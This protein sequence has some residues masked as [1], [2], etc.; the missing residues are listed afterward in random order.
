MT[1]LSDLLLWFFRKGIK[2][3]MT[4]LL[5]FAIIFAYFAV[6]DHW[7]DATSKA[8]SLADKISRLEKEA[9]NLL[10]ERDLRDAALQK[11]NE[12][13]PWKMDPRMVRWSW[14]Y[15]ALEKLLKKVEEDV[16]EK[17]QEIEAAR[18]ALDVFVGGEGKWIYLAEKVWGI[19]RP[20]ALWIL[21]PIFLAN[22]IWKV[23]WFYVVAPF[24]ARAEAIGVLPKSMP[25]KAIAKDS[26]R[27]HKIEVSADNPLC[28]KPDWVNK[29]KGPGLRKRTRI[30]WDFKSAFISYAAGLRFLTEWQPTGEETITIEVCS[31]EDPNQKVLRLDLGGLPGLVVK[32][33]HIVA[34]SGDVRVMTKWTLLNPHAWISGRLRHI[35]FYGTGSIYLK[36]YGDVVAET[37]TDSL[38]MADKLLLA[39]DPACQFRTVPTETF[40]PYCLGKV[41]LYDMEFGGGTMLVCQVAQSQADSSNEKATTSRVEGIV[42]LL[43]KPLGF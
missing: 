36:G 39:F 33:S 32:P 31:S 2:A 3:L 42:D 18:K 16:L 13:K 40:L 24:T 11:K 14:E 22:L 10:E 21:L 27:V 26:D 29:Y 6:K 8:K 19:L 5:A 25:T 20:L 12:T 41:S 30:L 7:E 17:K 15:K 1:L 28:T 35:I 34:M 9:K 37:H 23:F 4:I 43:L 38:R